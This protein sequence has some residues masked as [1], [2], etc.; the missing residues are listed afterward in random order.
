METAEQY[1][2]VNEITEPE[3]A[4]DMLNEFLTQSKENDYYLKW[5]IIAAH[6]ALQG[7]MVLA[8]KG[9]SALPIIKKE[10]W[11]TGLSPC[12]ILLDREHDQKID[13][14][15]DLFMKIKKAEYMQNSEFVDASG[16]ITRSVKKLNDF[17]NQFLHYPPSSWS[18]SLMGIYET[19]VDV[20][21]VITFLTQECSEV[22][23]E[24]ICSGSEHELCH[25]EAVVTECNHLLKER[26]RAITEKK[27]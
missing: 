4:L 19:L 26:A 23:R 21:T 24:Y 25:I 9:T 8:L 18:I 16:E 2:R 20:L 10:K 17:R 7:F 3:N 6:N 22:K 5:A 1:L 13:C 27:H 12:E 11:Q 15:M 14:F